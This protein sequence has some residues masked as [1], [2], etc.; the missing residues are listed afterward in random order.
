MAGPVAAAAVILPQ[1][2]EI[3]YLNDSKQLSEKKREALYD[4]IME[5]AVSV[6]VGLSSP[7]ELGRNQHFTGHLRGY[8]GGSFCNCSA[9]PAVL[10]NDAV[11]I[12]N[13]R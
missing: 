13:F 7:A 3:L 4:E 2:C 11:K 12:P 8:A 1:D 5:K 6:G 10:L 9:K